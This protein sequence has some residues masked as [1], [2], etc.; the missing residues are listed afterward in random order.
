MREVLR[1]LQELLWPIAEQA[2][3][4]D[5]RI[6]THWTV[7]ALKLGGRLRGG[8][9]STLGADGEHHWGG[10]PPVRQAG[11]LFELKAT[12][13]LAFLDSP[14]LA[15]R[16]IGLATVNA[17]LEVDL[18]ACREVN[19]EQVIME[20]GAG[21]K[22]AF[23]GHFPFVERV[24]ARAAVTWVFELNPREGDLPAERAPE[25]LPQADVIAITGT[26][27]LND[28]FEAIMRYR[29]PEA[30]VLLLGGTAPLTPVLF[31]YG[32]DLIAGTYLEDP[33]AALL[34]VSQGAT[35][36]QVRGKRLLTLARPS[37]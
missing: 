4:A 21:R 30:Y 10:E 20:R 7:A 31:D 28:T 23:I 22:V 13:W 35:F 29:S 6:G 15:E 26:T 2:E 8:I 18:A 24:R 25:F 12:D 19:A 5:I 37:Q 16:S 17:L 34:C 27:L 11:H 1:R 3:V 33:Q 14:S 32:V 9:A 36:K